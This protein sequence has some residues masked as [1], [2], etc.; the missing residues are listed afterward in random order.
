MISRRYGSCPTNGLQQNHETDK[1]RLNSQIA[2]RFPHLMIWL[3]RPQISQFQFAA[4]SRKSFRNASS[5]QLANSRKFFKKCVFK[6]SYRWRDNEFQQSA[7]QNRSPLQKQ[8]Q[9]TPCGAG[10]GIA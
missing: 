8:D 6:N 1:T 5:N 9:E 4:S 2:N 10:V 3:G 7:M